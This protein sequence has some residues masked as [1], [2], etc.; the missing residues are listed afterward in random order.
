[1]K[2]VLLVALLL[3]LITP[4]ASA[5]GIGGEVI[6]DTILF[7]PY[8]EKTYT[9]ALI[10]NAPK[11]MDHSVNLRGDLTEYITLSDKEFK[12]VPNKEMRV[13]TATFKLPQDLEPG[14][15]TTNICVTEGSTRSAGQVGA[16]T[17]V[18]ATITVRSLDY[19]KRIKATLSAENVEENVPIP[20][21][22]HVENWGRQDINLVNAKINIYDLD[23]LVG[24]VNTGSTSIVSGGAADLE[25]TYEPG[26]S[27]GSYDAIAT[28]AFDSDSIEARTNFKVGTLSVEITNYTNPLY[29]NHKNVLT[30]TLQNNWNKQIKNIYGD[31]KINGEVLKTTVTDI[32]PFSDSDVTTYWDTDGLEE[33]IYDAEVT[34][35]YEDTHSTETI[36][37]ELVNKSWFAGGAIA[38]PLTGSLLLL[39]ILV[40][41]LIGYYY[42]KKR[43][44]K[45]KYKYK[46][47]NEQQT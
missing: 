34:L 22:L 38:I 23:E 1:M 15:Y 17:S 28:V 5:V 33:G 29:T 31:V 30:L 9:F 16:K 21:K 44:P 43:K 45:R 41:A 27:V 12:D 46:S 10:S 14:S 3:I 20:F 13:F 19:N 24:S 36:E 42:Y 8:L 11:T 7:E 4:L 32:E 6:K 25:A 37:I 47:K 2:K 35:N 40:I 26:L 39:L 18:C